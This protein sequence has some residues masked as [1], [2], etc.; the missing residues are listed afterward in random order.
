MPHLTLEVLVKLSR[1]SDWSKVDYDSV[2]ILKPK[3]FVYTLKSIHQIVYLFADISFVG[4][5]S[6]Q[7]AYF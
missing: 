3:I 7:G 1:N 5:K 6:P 2:I 4:R